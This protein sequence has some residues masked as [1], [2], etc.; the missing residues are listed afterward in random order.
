[1]ECVPVVIQ[2]AGSGEAVACNMPFERI[3]QHAADP[4]FGP[5]PPEPK[6][7]ELHQTAAEPASA[8]MVTPKNLSEAY[9][10]HKAANKEVDLAMT[11]ARKLGEFLNAFAA[12]ATRNAAKGRP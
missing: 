2:E 3:P 8:G 7:V 12:E 11:K 9:E 10:A 4:G 5:V 1:M 6:V